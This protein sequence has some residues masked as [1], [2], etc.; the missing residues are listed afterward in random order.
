V[1]E[2]IPRVNQLLKKEFGSILSRGA[3]L[4]ENCLVSVSR[5]EATPNLQQAKIYIT[6][7]PADEKEEVLRSLQGQIYGI[8]QT[9]NKRLKMRPVPRIEIVFD[10]GELKAQKIR[11]ILDSL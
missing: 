5:V 8:Q 3:S 4:P 6:V 1:S 7:F 11:E 10:E 9:L 2:R